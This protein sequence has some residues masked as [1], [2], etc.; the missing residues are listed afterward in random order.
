MSPI[1]L[2]VSLVVAVALYCLAA[3]HLERT[4]GRRAVWIVAILAG[5]IAATLVAVTSG[6]G[7]TWS[8][9]SRVGKFAAV[10]IAVTMPFVAAAFAIQRASSSLLGRRWQ[11]A[12]GFALGAAA[13]AI[14]P[15]VGLVLVCAFTGDCL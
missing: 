14:S 15:V 12:I 2:I 7:F 1:V 13:A 8:T 11:T 10:L 4:R 3:E 6:I 5:I 9:V